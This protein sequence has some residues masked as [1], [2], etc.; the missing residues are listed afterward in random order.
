MRASHSKRSYSMNQLY[1][2]IGIRKQAVHKHQNRFLDEQD[3]LVALAA[4]VDQIR[5]EH[6]GCG[7]EKMY[8]MINPQGIGRDKFIEAMMKMG[9]GIQRPKNFIRTTYSIKENYYPNLISGLQILFINRV[10]QTDITYYLVGNKFCYITFIIDVYSRRI[11]GHYASE[12]LRAEAN[13]KAL[14]MAF[15]TRKAMDL[16]LLIHHSDRGSQYIDKQYIKLLKE[17][18]IAISMSIN[19]YENAYAERI[20]GIIK[21]EY[22]KYKSIE[23]ITQLRSQLSKAVNHYNN[24]RIHN[25]LP[26]RQSP[27]KFEEEILSLTTQRRPKVIVYAEGNYKI[28]EASSLLDFN[29]EEEPRAHVCPIKM[30]EELLTKTV[31]QIQG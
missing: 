28:K 12:S 13:I 31:N 16:D 5:S 7:V 21:N 18:N 27:V 30:N 3:R 15:K 23:S 17:N 19:A 9:Y 29:P 2:V 20:N 6:G 14:T 22:L 24:K 1:A 26:I 11:I 4:E 25:S 8:Y 10:W